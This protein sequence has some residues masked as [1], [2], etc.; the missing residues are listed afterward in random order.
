M[1]EEEKQRDQAVGAAACEIA[2]IIAETRHAQLHG[3]AGAPRLLCA[4]GRAGGRRYARAIKGQR[5]DGRYCAQGGVLY[6]H[7]CLQ[8]WLSHKP[9]MIKI[10][11]KKSCVKKLRREQQKGGTDRP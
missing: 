10:K 4:K 7:A 8:R 1:P 6:R 11:Y 2:A 3:E 9:I 5:R